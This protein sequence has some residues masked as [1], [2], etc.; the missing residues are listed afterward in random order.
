MHT[1][2]NYTAC[3]LVVGLGDIEDDDGYFAG[4]PWR[5]VL[6]ANYV[7]DDVGHADEGGRPGAE[8]KAQATSRAMSSAGAELVSLPTEMKSTPVAA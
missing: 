4:A 3:L 5:N 8:T 1:N 6:A 2:T 7:V